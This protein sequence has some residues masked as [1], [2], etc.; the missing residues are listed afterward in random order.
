MAWIQ[1]VETDVLTVLS[2]PELEGI[3]AA[4]LDAVQPDPVAPT[5]AQVVAL[6]RG[7]VAGNP[8]NLL[9]TGETIPSKLMAPALD[10]IAVR[11]PQR[12]GQSPSEGRK[13]A[14]RTA[15]RLLERVAEGKFDIE[16]PAD[17]EAGTGGASVEIANKSDRLTGRTKLQGL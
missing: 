13:E 8:A 11:I 1:I 16:E 12:V 17:P 14:A 9:G 15:V 4:A 6:V 2:G 10:L 3:R 5:I 7:Y